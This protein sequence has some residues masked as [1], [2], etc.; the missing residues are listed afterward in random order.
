[1]LSQRANIT[2]L[3]FGD[4]D[5][6]TSDL[7]KIYERTI[8]VPPP[9]GYSLDKMV[10]GAVGR[11]PLPLLN[12]TTEQM[13][14]ALAKLLAE[15]HFDVIQVESIHLMNYLPIVRS[16]S[17]GSVVVCDWHN[18]ESELMEQYSDHANL[19]RR[20]Y[21]RKTARLMKEA[22]KRALDEFDAHLAVSHGDAERMQSVNRAANIS[23]IE[24]GVDARHFAIEDCDPKRRLVFVGSM[25]YHANIE[26]AITFAR[27][28]WP[29]L[30]QRKP[31]IIFTIVGRD[32]APAVRQLSSLPA[33][34]VTGS[35]ED[36]RPYYR[37]AFAAV[38]PL[39]VG[40][41][42]R[43]K[44]LEAMAAGVPVV[45]TSQGAEGLEVLNSENILLADGPPQLVEAVTK[46]IDDEPLR[47]KLIESARKL[48]TERYDWA[49]LGAKLHSYYTQILSA[50]AR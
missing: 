12:Y 30:H 19:A 17:P 35:V 38:V 32:P 3:A 48:V 11:T 50:R 22:E 23:V 42:S 47:R 16:R 31:Q 41:G 24:N 7:E 29:E 5:P 2:L 40:G 14:Q 25:D 9:R 36:V 44:I 15:N 18:I 49:I 26:G 39:N 1:V 8:P 45:S 21:A 13:K 46:V 4:H 28:V 37:D 33:I 43:L 27:D 20:V 10:L 34:E 6:S